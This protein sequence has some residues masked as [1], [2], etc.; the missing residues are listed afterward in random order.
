VE[1]DTLTLREAAEALG[2]SYKTL[3]YQR[4]QGRLRATLRQ[5]SRGPVWVVIHEDV[6]RY[7]REQR[8][9]HAHTTEEQAHV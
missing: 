6:D 1:A 3:T 4:H 8:A 7:R 9:G 2:L 5:E